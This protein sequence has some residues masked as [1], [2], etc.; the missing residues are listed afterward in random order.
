M[1]TLLSIYD[2]AFSAYIL[3]TMPG[4]QLYYSFYIQGIL[5]W[6]LIYNRPHDCQPCTQVSYLG[7]NLIIVEIFYMARVLQQL[8]GF[9]NEWSISLSFL[10]CFYS[11]CLYFLPLQWHCCVYGNEVCGQYCEG[12]IGNHYF[13]LVN[14]SLMY[15]YMHLYNYPGIL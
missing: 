5:P 7:C 14:P 11:S 9:D 15:F 3:R 12:K 1:Q 10:L 2:P 4:F 8:I 13:Y 6:I